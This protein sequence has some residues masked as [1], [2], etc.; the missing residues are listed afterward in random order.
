MEKRIEHKNVACIDVLLV[1]YYIFLCWWGVF[2]IEVV[3]VMV[4]LGALFVKAGTFDIY[5]YV[6]FARSLARCSHNNHKAYQ[7]SQ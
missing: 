5:F 4:R 3:V 7:Q 6:L 2:L 1:F